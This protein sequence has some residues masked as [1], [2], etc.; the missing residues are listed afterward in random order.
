MPIKRDAQGFYYL[1]EEEP[2]VDESKVIEAT[3][4]TA[5]A[6]KEPEDMKNAFGQDVLKVK[7]TRKPRTKKDP[8]AVLKVRRTRRRK[9]I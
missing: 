4:S 3:A 5:T 9:V 6:E 7:K 1:A 8:L 2:T